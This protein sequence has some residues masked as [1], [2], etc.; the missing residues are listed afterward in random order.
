MSEIFKKQ[1]ANGLTNILLKQLKKPIAYP[2]LMIAKLLYFAI[3]R[4]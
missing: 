4:P 1:V 3:L 2:Q